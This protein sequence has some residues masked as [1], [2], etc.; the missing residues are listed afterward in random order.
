LTAFAV[1]LRPLMHI[2]CWVH[3]VS[4]CQNVGRMRTTGMFVSAIN[5]FYAVLDVRIGTSPSIFISNVS[6]SS[7]SRQFYGFVLNAYDDV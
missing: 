3:S 4:R 5:L 7:R 6:H 2:D 1:M